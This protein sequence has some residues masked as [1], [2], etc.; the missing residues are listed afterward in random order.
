MSGYIYCF[1]NDS[2]PGIYKIGLSIDVNRRSKELHTTGVPTP[3]KV[4]YTK[5]V[6]NMKDSEKQAHRFLA[7]Y[8]I[9]K[10]REFFETS[11]E[12][13]KKV[14]DG[15]PGEFV[16]IDYDPMEVGGESENEMDTTPD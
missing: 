16:T 3:F 9:S 1:A 14:F 2:M 11:L 12:K 10:K 6:D 5:K 4:I 7:K 13:I 15:I 8:R